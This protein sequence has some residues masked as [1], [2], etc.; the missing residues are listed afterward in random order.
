PVT[1]AADDAASPGVTGA[2]HPEPRAPFVGRAAALSALTAAVSRAVTGRGGVALV[3]GE[4]GI[5]KT[6]LVEELVAVSGGVRVLRAPCWS[7]E[8]A[9]ELWPFASLMRDLHDD[10][11]ALPE[12]VAAWAGAALAAEAH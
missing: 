9:P 2:P 12:D 11:E 4:A 7:G 5:G 10:G 8:G 1:L 3:S 6:R